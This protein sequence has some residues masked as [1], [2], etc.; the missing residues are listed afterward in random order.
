MTAS[1]VAV[2]ACNAAPGADVLAKQG[3][4]SKKTSASR[5][6]AVSESR[7]APLPP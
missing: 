2:V 7:A 6:G 3:P 4:A 5:N 1:W